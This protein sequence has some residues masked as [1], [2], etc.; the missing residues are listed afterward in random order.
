VVKRAY[1]E[2]RE[3]APYLKRLAFY[4]ITEEEA[5]QFEWVHLTGSK[6][7]DIDVVVTLDEDDLEVMQR[8]LDCYV[9]YA[10]TIEESGIKR[11]IPRE[12]VFEIYQE[13]HEPALMGLCDGLTEAE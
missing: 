6:P 7:E 3:R 5:A 12:A 11:D 8:A 9:T 2:L 4:T 10:A 13:A 1:V